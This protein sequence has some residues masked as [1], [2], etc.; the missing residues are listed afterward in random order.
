M[1]SIFPKLLDTGLPCGTRRPVG[2]I[3]WLD[4]SRFRKLL[5]ILISRRLRGVRGKTNTLT[6]LYEVVVDEDAM[7]VHRDDHGHVGTVE[8][9]LES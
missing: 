3:S 9:V 1:Q 5:N 6:L 2:A 4:V 7:V 8:H